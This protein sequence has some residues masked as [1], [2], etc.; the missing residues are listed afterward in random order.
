MFR[1]YQENKNNNIEI[2]T[3]DQV[4]EQD[5]REMSVSAIPDVIELSNQMIEFL[6][7]Y[8]KPDIVNMRKN[9]YPNYLNA[10]Y[11]KFSKMPASMISL[12][13]DEK[14]RA[15]NLSKLIDMLETLGR[16]KKGEKNIEEARDEFLE[17]NNEEYFYP[18]FGGKEQLIKDIENKSGKSITDIDINNIT[19]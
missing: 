2:I 14:N 4:R 3:E 13:S 19:K 17:Q 9:N 6:E 15:Q 8:D 7:F 10:M 12:L 18:A 16:I 5:K 1:N 11:D